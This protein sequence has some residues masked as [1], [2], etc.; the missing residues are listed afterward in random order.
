M[1]AQSHS[2]ECAHDNCTT[3]ETTY[4]VRSLHG[5]LEHK[6]KA[7]INV[8]QVAHRAPFKDKE[9]MHPKPEDSPHGRYTIMKQAWTSLKEDNR[10]CSFITKKMRINNRCPQ[11]S[12]PLL[13]VEIQHC[14]RSHNHSRSHDHNRNQDQ[15]QQ[16][17]QR[18]SL[19]GIHLKAVATA[20]SRIKH[21]GLKRC[22]FEKGIEESAEHCAEHN[23]RSGVHGALL[24][25]LPQNGS[26]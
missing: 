18:S 6:C 3:L 11:A 14:C 13:T 2:D 25:T 12:E 1:R 17:P 20:V 22:I 16:K 26:L 8:I 7:E 10:V 24:S 19:K 21:V 4:R 15:S 9:H 5:W 23:C